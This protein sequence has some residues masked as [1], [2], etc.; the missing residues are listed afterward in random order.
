MRLVHVNFLAGDPFRSTARD[1]DSAQ[2]RPNVAKS[3]EPKS[4]EPIDAS[5]TNVAL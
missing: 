2:P 4:P 3:V 5:R 1:V